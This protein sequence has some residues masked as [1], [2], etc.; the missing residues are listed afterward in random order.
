M[1]SQEDSPRGST[2]AGL[3]P[4][5]SVDSGAT[6]AK[7]LTLLANN[8]IPGPVDNSGG[9]GT[10]AFKSG[11]HVC[12]TIHV[13]NTDAGEPT[14]N[15]VKMAMDAV[16][17]ML[18][19]DVSRAVIGLEQ[20][21]QGRWHGQGYAS[22]VKGKKLSQLRTL[23]KNGNELL[24][25]QSGH[26]GLT[27]HF[28]RARGNP[29]QNLDYCSKSTEY[30]LK[31]GEF[32]DKLDQG[33]RTDLLNLITW[34]EENGSMPNAEWDLLK[35]H[36]EVFFRHPKATQ[37]VLFLARKRARRQAGYLQPIVHLYWGDAGTGK[38]RKAQW[39]A[40]QVAGDA[41]SVYRQPPGKWWPGLDGE[42]VI[43]LDDFRDEW[44]TPS[45][46]LQ[47]LDGYPFTVEDKGTHAVPSFTHIF[48]TSNERIDDWWK[49]AREK[50][51]YSQTWGA[52]R[53][54]FT[55]IEHFTNAMFPD[56]WKP[57]TTSTERNE[58]QD[59]NSKIEAE[60]DTNIP[61]NDWEWEC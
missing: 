4:T 41:V 15:M 27:M 58:E 52:I 44:C 2:S 21:L 51:P 7:N 28:I 55:H 61:L 49:E 33:K 11:K 48:V 29:K 43:I 42:R 45:T 12:F 8:L 22:F 53:R 31:T 38:S 34:C 25:G 20:G 17:T 37:R 13:T 46:L 54:R 23:A 32:P 40:E 47:W 50:K 10:T 30:L 39:E 36:P 35:L 16:W 9:Q 5:L 18:V 1:S 14:S 56:C 59:T 3:V 57:P 6:A 26:P 24:I 60:M 19:P